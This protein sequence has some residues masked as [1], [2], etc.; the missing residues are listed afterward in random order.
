MANA[1]AMLELQRVKLDFQSLGN[2]QIG[3]KVKNSSVK[4]NNEND[5][6]IALRQLPSGVS[7]PA[8]LLAK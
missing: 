4:D 5:E 6:K 8:V 2:L 7:P 3:S 1:I